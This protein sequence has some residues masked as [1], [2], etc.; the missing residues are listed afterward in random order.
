MVEKD[1]S[2]MS[3]TRDWTGFIWQHLWLCIS[4][5]VMT[6]GVALCVRSALGSSVISTIPFVMTLAGEE[7]LAKG[8]SIGEWTYVMNFILVGTQILILRRKFETAQLLQL[9]IGFLF[10]W[11]LDVNMALTSIFP[12]SGI[13]WQ[14]VAQ[15]TG[16]TVLGIGIAFEIKCGSVTMPG[17]GLPA[18]ICKISGEQFAKIKIC[19]DVALVAIAV[20]LG[21]VYFGRWLWQVVGIGTLFAMI[22]VGAV[23]KIVTP[24]I[25]W[26]DS[27]LSSRPGFKRYLYG[28]AHFLHTRR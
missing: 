8:L 11:L 12:V 2:V 18:A 15:F 25:G 5:F 20:I 28:L 4:L 24:R 1:L 16:C 13:V 22:Y 6:F 7:G 23:V 26:F 21:Y 14:M 19:V 3:K 9:V 17:E 10:G 27:L